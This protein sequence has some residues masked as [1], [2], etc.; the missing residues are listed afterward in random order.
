MNCKLSPLQLALATTSY[1]ANLHLLKVEL[2]MTFEARSLFIMNLKC[3]SK[4]G[5]KM[6]NLQQTI[7][8]SKT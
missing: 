5:I 1:I 3:D 6:T 2:N 8:P 7:K 4:K